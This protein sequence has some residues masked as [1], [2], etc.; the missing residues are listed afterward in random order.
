MER[1]TSLFNSQMLTGK[2]VSIYEH[3][4]AGRDLYK[5]MFE[6]LGAEV[7]TLERSDKFV[8]IDTEA[9]SGADKQKS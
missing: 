5:P 7:I 2:R 4:S 6:A 9:V 3:S 8:P 1:Y